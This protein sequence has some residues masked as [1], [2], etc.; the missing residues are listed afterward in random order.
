MI[1][2]AVALGKWPRRA[3]FRDLDSLG[4][5]NTNA[6]NMKA[7]GLSQAE[8]ELGAG[9]SGYRRGS[10]QTG[11]QSHGGFPQGIERSPAHHALD[12]SPPRNGREMIRARQSIDNRKATRAK[13]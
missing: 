5:Q 4:T 3:I 11:Q 12:N 6:L 13:G 1:C 2:S 10:G 9:A 7:Q 8:V